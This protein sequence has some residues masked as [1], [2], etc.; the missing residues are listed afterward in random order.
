MPKVLVVYESLATPCTM[1]RG[2]Q[3]RDCFEADPELDAT[4][5]GRT[6]ERMNRLMQRWPWRP[7]IR[8]PAIWAEQQIL[9]RRENRIVGL[10]QDSDLVLL[11]TVPSWSLHQRLADLGR[12]KLVT[13]LIDALWLPSF[14]H[15]G[16]QNIHEMLSTSDAVICEN[17][18]TAEYTRQYNANVTVVPDA[19]QIEVFDQHRDSARREHATCRIG[20]VGGKYTADALY[21]IFEP[22]ERLF[23]KHPDLELRLVGA[24]PDRLPRFEKVR[25]TVQPAYDQTMMVRE[26]L[27]MDIGIF[28]MFDT[29]E[30]LY[31]G[32]LKSRVSMAGEAAFIGQRLGENTFL[33]DEEKN[34]LLAADEQEWF[35]CLD[36]L[37]VDSEFRKRIATAGLGTIREQFTRDLCYRQLRESLVS[38][39]AK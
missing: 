37:V 18:F 11:L 28:P 24:D 17:R 1:V 13:D 32:A 19:P 33:V 23:S 2:L 12:P 27:G 22:L 36:R 21:R 14:Q 9:R 26:V 39:L 16:W 30:S 34:G 10:A 7:S 31:R 4:F 5:I 15:Q 25:F 20:W 3:F 6:D 35:H 29:A 8:R 38:I